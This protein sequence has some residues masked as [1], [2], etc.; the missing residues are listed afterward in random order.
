[1]VVCDSTQKLMRAS[2]LLHQ[3]T[4]PRSTADSHRL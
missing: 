4:Q 2:Q 3:N 1:M